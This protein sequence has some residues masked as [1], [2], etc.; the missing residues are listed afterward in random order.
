MEDEEQNPK[1]EY[2]FNVKPELRHAIRRDWGLFYKKGHLYDKALENFDESL[3]INEDAFKP[4]IEKSRC[5]L[6]EC[7]PD[8]ALRV[9]KQCKTKYPKIVRVKYHRNNCLYEQNN[10]EDSLKMAW[11]TM[12]QHPTARHV[13]SY[14]ELINS[15]IEQSIE[16]PKNCLYNMRLDIDRL[17]RYK[18]NAADCRPIWKILRDANECDVISTR[19]TSYTDI[20]PIKEKQREANAN[21]I[22]SMYLDSSSAKDIIFLKS[23]V[24]SDRLML[25][26]TPKS[27]AVLVENINKHMKCIVACE[28][29]LWT[30]EPCYAKTYTEDVARTNRT[31]VE[32]LHRSQHHTRINAFLHLA[33]IKRLQKTNFEAMLKY[34]DKIMSTVYATKTQRVFPRKFEFVN[35]V[36]NIVG[37]AY[38]NRLR[39]PNNIMTVP[40]EQ[41]MHLL[42]DERLEQKPKDDDAIVSAA[43][44]FSDRKAF[45][46][47]EAPDESYLAYKR[48]VDHYE[49]ILL[50]SEYPIEKC[51]LY[52][53][54]ANLHLSH[55]KLDE[56]KQLALKIV[57]FAT[58]C[59]N[60]VWI[61]HGFLAMIRVDLAQGNPT[62][63]AKKLSKLLTIRHLLDEDARHFV[64]TAF[65]IN[66]VDDEQK[67]AKK[68]I[69]EVSFQD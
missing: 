7:N 28:Q 30:R 33:K 65:L 23:L 17:H 15:T 26:Q 5:L 48:Q 43:K 57:E 39:V 46:D 52:H 37:L 34:V 36:Y 59:G 22:H 47:P 53:E 12:H 20:A 63:M 60:Y 10:F 51:Y 16:S 41:R 67:F 29:M 45:I 38:L 8:E 62:K 9:A 4:M 21:R 61:V 2:I 6:E 11:Q 24:T 19:S 44:I 56:T 68:N 64:K 40:Q 31:K 55:R 54:I 18:L 25:P 1:K 49:R 14:I 13:K 66:E 27:N 35:E 32:V 69:K 42:L 50:H 58:V 3:A